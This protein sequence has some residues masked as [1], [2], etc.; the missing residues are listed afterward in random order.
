MSESAPVRKVRS[1]V[2]REGRMTPAQR[3]ALE[4]CWPRYG[5]AVQDSPLNLDD[6]FGR[7]AP[8]MLEI[9][10]GMG[11]SL[12]AMAAAHPENDYL[13][14]EVYRPGIGTLMRRL[15]EAGLDNVRIVNEDAVFVLERM[16]PVEA[17][18]AIYLFFPDPWPKKRHHKR[19]I[20]QPPFIELVRSRL[21]PGGMLH[22]ATDWQDYAQH[23]L[24]VMKQ[25]ESFR[26]IAGAGCCAE[27]PPWRPLTKYEQ[28]GRRLGHQ[29]CDL[30]FERV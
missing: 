4:R 7:Q 13:A 15:A 26:N 3:R 16:L 6:L 2:R 25:V 18:A 19:R 1:F 23:M 12:L 29:V 30:I 14:I 8:R 11:E 9:G 27:R 10:C 17:F 20:V 21:K 5:V 24:A 28:R 22:M